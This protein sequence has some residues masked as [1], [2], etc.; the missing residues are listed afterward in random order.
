[1]DEGWVMVYGKTGLW[2]PESWRYVDRLYR[3]EELRISVR[4]LGSWGLQL[5]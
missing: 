2:F 1:M 3:H 4:V 5:T